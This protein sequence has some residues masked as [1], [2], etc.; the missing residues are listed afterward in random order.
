MRL[1]PAVAG[2]SSCSA[3]SWRYGCARCAR[4][5]SPPNA[6][7]GCRLFSFKWAVALSRAQHILSV[8]AARG[9]VLVPERPVSAA[10]LQKSCGLGCVPFMEGASDLRGL[11]GQQS[12]HRKLETETLRQR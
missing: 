10:V 9:D 12:A 2:A 8:L 5:Q 11:C 3:C 1:A 7:E 6:Q 4:I